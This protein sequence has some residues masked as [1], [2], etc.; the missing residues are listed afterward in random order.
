MI[1]QESFSVLTGG[2]ALFSTWT[3]GKLG[4]VGM[5]KKMR[6]NFFKMLDKPKSIWYYYMVHFIGGSM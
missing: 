4:V 3:R 2:E 5:S 1:I 6:K